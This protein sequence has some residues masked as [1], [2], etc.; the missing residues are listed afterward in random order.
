MRLLSEIIITG[1]LH[2]S[3][4]QLLQGDLT[5]IPKEHHTDILVVSAF[6]NDYTP[7]PGSLMYAL[8]EKGIDVGELAKD[9]AVNLVQE[10]G[11]WLSRPLSKAQQEQFNFKQILC[12]EPTRQAG[13]PETIVGN[14][15]RCINN[16]VFGDENNVIAMPVLASGKQKVPIEKML[17]AMLDAC[18]FWLESGVPLDCIKLM[19]HRDEQVEAALP[20]FERARKKHAGQDATPAPAPIPAAAPIVP[21]AAIGT[22][23]PLAAVPPPTP[24]PSSPSAIPAAAPSPSASVPGPA[25]V[26]VP[27]PPVPAYAGK[28]DYDFFISYSHLQSEQVAELVKALKEKDSSLNIF[29]DRSSIPTGGL[30]IRL[31]SDAI[32][33]SKSVVCVLSPQYRN[34]DV[35]WDEFQC[36]KAK[37]YRTKKPV[38]K[39]INFM[40]DS[41]MPLIMSLYSWIDCTEGDVNKLKDAVAM[42][43]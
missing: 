33:R 34:S 24:A 19:L 1:P 22:P 25:L 12:F 8:H 7:L 35:C 27:A 36:A 3:S 32:Q 30:W 5:A 39:T 43:L 42:L 14:I 16:F 29:Y 17:P 21:V 4:V 26:P 31:I 18:I 37:E 23:R 28:A 2:N 11:C 15:F 10:L 20:V 40:T 9:K 13:A 41:D 6:P 38:I